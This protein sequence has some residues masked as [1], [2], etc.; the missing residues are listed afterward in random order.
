MFFAE[1]IVSKPVAGVVFSESQIIVGK[2]VS[3]FPEKLT[4]S[5]EELNLDLADPENSVQSSPTRQEINSDLLTAT[6]Q[7]GGKICVSFVFLV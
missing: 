2:D 7:N 6:D 5:E 4:E 1:I 3:S